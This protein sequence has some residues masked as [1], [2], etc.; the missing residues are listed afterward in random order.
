MDERKNRI[1]KLF[2]DVFVVQ[3]SLGEMKEKYALERQVGEQRS[4]DFFAPC[5]Q[6]LSNYP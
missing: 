2:T 4:R 5:Y 3:A 1:K 6:Q